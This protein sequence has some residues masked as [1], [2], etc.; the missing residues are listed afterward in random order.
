MCHHKTKVNVRKFIC[1]LHTV[2][3]RCSSE[4]VC[5][6]KSW[7]RHA[8][9]PFFSFPRPTVMCESFSSRCTR[10][11]AQLFHTPSLSLSPT[12]LFSKFKHWSKFVI[13]TRLQLN[14]IYDPIFQVR[15]ASLGKWIKAIWKVFFLLFVVVWCFTC[16]LVSVCGGAASAFFS[17]DAKHQPRD[18]D[19]GWVGLGWGFLVILCAL[20]CSA[21][22]LYT[23]NTLCM[24]FTCIKTLQW[25]NQM[26]YR[27]CFLSLSF[28]FTS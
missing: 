22:K 8:C 21:V 19:V 26:R 11:L 16:I 4:T 15:Q 1:K 27:C 17:L 18:T 12:S 3:G 25:G 2:G 6:E 20:Q 10:T 24:Q 9:L 7:S 14:I 23:N 13:A 28:A 5:L